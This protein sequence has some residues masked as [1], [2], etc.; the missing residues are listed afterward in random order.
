MAAI[1]QVAL[2]DDQRRLQIYGGAIRP[3][4][5]GAVHA[6]PAL[7]ADR[8]AT[9]R[10]DDVEHNG[11]LAR[12]APMATATTGARATLA[13]RTIPREAPIKITAMR[14]RR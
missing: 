5:A 12:V 1:H 14:L 4:P 11:F 13:T 3:D 7:G 8:H 6:H 10:G 2:N 9:E